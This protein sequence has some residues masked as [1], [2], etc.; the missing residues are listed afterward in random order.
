MRIWHRAV[1]LKVRDLMAR[2]SSFCRPREWNEKVHFV[3]NHLQ[4][5][6]L[7]CLSK[8]EQSPLFDSLVWIWGLAVGTFS[9]AHP[10]FNIWNINMRIVANPHGTFPCQISIYIYSKYNTSYNLHIS[11]INKSTFLEMES[12][13]HVPLLS[14]RTSKWP[15]NG[16]T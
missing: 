10:E 2:A 12:Q 8:N 1:T 16:V 4:Y 6:Y 14:F 5:P 11:I 13:P 9:H 3:G 15:L 7:L